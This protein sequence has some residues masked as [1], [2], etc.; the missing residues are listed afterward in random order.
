MIY[1]I[2]L[3]HISDLDHDLYYLSARS[4]WSRSWSSWF[5]FRSIWSISWY[6]LS[7]CPI[8]LIYITIYLADLSNIDHGLSD[9]SVR[10]IWSRS[11]SDLSDLVY[12]NNYLSNT[13]VRFIWS[14]LIYLFNLSN[15]DHHLSDLS[16][17]WFW[18]RSW[19]GL[20]VDLRDLDHDI[21]VRYM[22]FRSWPIWSICPM[23]CI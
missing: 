5:K 15:L 18:S 3:S 7:F 13:S 12:L 1:L 19:S 22:W 20:S 11:L 10:Y 23:Y 16:V 21:S 9:L 6:I 2:Y 14:D 8:N 17:R 4:I